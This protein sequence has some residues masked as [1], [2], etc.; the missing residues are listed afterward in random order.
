MKWMDYWHDHIMY[1][2]VYRNEKQ[3]SLV[4]D[5]LHTR[6]RNNETKVHTMKRLKSLSLHIELQ[7]KSSKLLQQRSKQKF[8]HHNMPDIDYKSEYRS[9]FILDRHHLQVELMFGSCYFNQF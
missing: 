6:A 2:R 4:H 7:S 3:R 1:E 8:I 9:D 5:T